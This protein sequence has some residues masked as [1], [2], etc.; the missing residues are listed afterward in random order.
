MVE[1]PVRQ[2]GQTAAARLVQRI[3]GRGA[4]AARTRALRGRLVERDSVAAPRA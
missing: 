4:G 2:L 1:Q 3:E